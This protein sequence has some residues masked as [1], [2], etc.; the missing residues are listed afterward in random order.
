[1]RIALHLSLPLEVFEGSIEVKSIISIME[2]DSDPH[3]SA[4]VTGQLDGV[5]SAAVH[6]FLDR[7]FEVVSDDSFSVLLAFKA[8]EFDHAGLAYG[9]DSDVAWIEASLPVQ[10]FSFQLPKRWPLGFEAGGILN[11]R[12]FCFCKSVYSY[13]KGVV[14]IT[15]NYNQD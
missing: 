2:A 12:M 15:V 13:W 10:M 11:M 8:H 7:V 3:T 5:A 9:R 1:M 4:I 6:D 14:L